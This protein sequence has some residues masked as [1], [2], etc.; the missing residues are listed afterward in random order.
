MGSVLI[1]SGA[2][3]GNKRECIRP[4]FDFEAYSTHLLIADGQVFVDMKVKSLGLETSL[5][6]TYGHVGGIAS[7]VSSQT[8][9]AVKCP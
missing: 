4:A 8:V 6:W 5:R 9:R 7:E 1:F 3:E 2:V